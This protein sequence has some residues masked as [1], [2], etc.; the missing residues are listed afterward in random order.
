M[1][2]FRFGFGTSQ[3][4]CRRARLCLFVSPWL[5]LVFA[6]HT[7]AGADEL[8]KYGYDRRADFVAQAAAMTS[9]L[10]PPSIE[11]RCKRASASR[12]V[13]PEP[14]Q[15][16][17]EYGEPEDEQSYLRRAEEAKDSITGKLLR[18]R[19]LYL[20]EISGDPGKRA[21]F[22][23]LTELPVDWDKAA[24]EEPQPDE[25]YNP[26]NQRQPDMILTAESGWSFGDIG[27]GPD[28]KAQ[29]RAAIDR[30]RAEL[31]QEPV[32]WDAHNKRQAQ[33]EEEDE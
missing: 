24:R 29:A 1:R 8:Y 26:A 32:D 4:L 23:I 15:V 19:R 11:Q 5:L 33:E 31:G 18:I 30:R 17:N 27:Y 28:R 25:P 21:A 22:E 14:G 20:Q 7:A 16:L 9:N 3:T 6:L 2:C 13:E 12:P 10:V